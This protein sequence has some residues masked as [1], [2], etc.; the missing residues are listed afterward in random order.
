MNGYYFEYPILAII[1]ILFLLCE[2]FCKE[3]RNSFY[4]PHLSSFAAPS[5][6]QGR[7]LQLLKWLAIIMLTLGIM[8][9][10]K[11]SV[12]ETM[13]DKGYDIALVLDTS[14]S[15]AARG[16]N[17]NNYRETRF[18]VVQSI[19]RDF[20]K[21]RVND[22]LG[23]VVF[24]KFSFIASPLT[25]DQKILGTI[26]EQ[27]SIGMAGKYTALYEAVGQGVNLLKNSK[28]KNKIMILLTDGE[29]TAG[30]M[31]LET[32]VALAKKEGIKIYAIGIGSK[33]E[34]NLAVLSKLA[35]ETNGEAFAASSAKQ[36][37]Q[38]YKKIDSLEKSK[39]E[40]EKFKFKDYFYIYPLFIGFFALLGFVY[41]RNMRS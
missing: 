33:R 7:L 28:A 25:Y 39:I 40:H 11:D 18:D 29:N 34:L 16:F 15:M 22:N 30:E 19:V 35:K 12:I 24:G 23:V 3:K 32:A 1:P 26:I 2:K 17:P 4:F 10:V 14:E 31:S 41:F 9:P 21:T 8:S 38:V 37:E 13:P 20:V 27:L 6:A 36:L 5:M